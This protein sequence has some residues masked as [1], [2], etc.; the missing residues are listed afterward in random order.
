MIKTTFSK[1][2]LATG[3][4]IGTF[5]LSSSCMQ[6]PELDDNDGA[7]AAP[8]A[9][10]ESLL[11]AW[12]NADANTIKV[13]EFTFAEKTLKISSLNP[14]QTL[15]EGIT[16]SLIENQTDQKLIHL[17]RQTEEFT[18]NNQ[19][20]LSTS[21]QI[22]SVK[23]TSST[24]PTSAEVLSSLSTLSPPLQQQTA[25]TDLG[26]QVLSGLLSSCIPSPDW[27]VQCFNLRSD[28]FMSDPPELVKARPNCDGIPNCK[29]RIK[30]VQFDL[31]LTTTEND[32]RTKVKQ[33]ALYSI[34]FS[35]D[36]PYLARMTEWC[37]Q[38]LGTLQ[39]QKIPVKF[40]Q[41][42][43]DFRKGQ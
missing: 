16:V 22:L 34:S 27:D 29:I 26:V 38:G 8:A 3:L 6:K 43:L 21:E 12:D 20:K 15:K 7:P 2:L 35:P 18:D 33:K 24:D 36:L 39:N 42:V 13:Q 37:Y 19:S 31:V 5:A 32:G 9:V 25:G 4:V 40:C 1:S 30:R 28:T 14:R 11:S 41:N 17:L 23:K 10:Q